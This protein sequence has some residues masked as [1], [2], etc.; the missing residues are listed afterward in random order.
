VRRR[1]KTDN[2]FAS[3]H[4]CKFPGHAAGD[5]PAAASVAQNKLL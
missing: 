1:N 2:L 3:F 4:G 5:A